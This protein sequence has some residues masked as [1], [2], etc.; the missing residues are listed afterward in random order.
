MSKNLLP[1]YYVEFPQI[2]AADAQLRSSRQFI[3]EQAAERDAEREELLGQ[4][5]QLK[6]ALREQKHAVSF[7]NEAKLLEQQLEEAQKQIKVS[8]A[9][10]ERM[11]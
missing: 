5:E 11:G 4:I 7:D 2:E 8:E 6:A 10:I 3:E 1:T 9:R